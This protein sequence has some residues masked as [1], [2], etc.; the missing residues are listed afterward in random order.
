MF[1]SFTLDVFYNKISNFSIGIL[2]FF[3]FFRNFLIFSGNLHNPF[4]ISLDSPGFF[5]YT[6]PN[7]FL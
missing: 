7:N 2:Y 5:C 1:Y 4:F 3:Y 6:L